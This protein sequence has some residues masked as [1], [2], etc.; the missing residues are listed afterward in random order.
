MEKYDK[1]VERKIKNLELELRK[2]AVEDYIDVEK[3]VEAKE[4]GNAAFRDGK[5]P[6]AI[7]EYEDAIKRDPKN[8]EIF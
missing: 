1:A 4:R 3:G 7:K 6:E 5:F 8:G 2:K